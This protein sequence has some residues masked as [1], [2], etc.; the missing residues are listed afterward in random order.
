MSLTTESEAEVCGI[1]S[2]P[3]EAHKDMVHQ[4]QPKN[5]PRTLVARDDSSHDQRKH[6][7]GESQGRPRNASSGDP[8]LR[9]AL[10]RKGVITVEDLDAV[11]AELRATG[12]AGYEPPASVG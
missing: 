8:V 6:A 2:R 9:M 11:D 4:F 1:C 7:P 12:V 3:K 10:I 5:G